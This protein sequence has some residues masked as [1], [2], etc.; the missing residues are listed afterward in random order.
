MTELSCPER[1]H[2]GA[3]ASGLLHGDEAT[4]L[5][6]HAELCPPC[7][8]ELADLESVVKTLRRTDL[9]MIDQDSPWPDSD[10][11]TV[12]GIRGLDS[13]ILNRIDT[14]KRLVKSRRRLVTV[15]AS[16][17][18][19]VAIAGG[20]AVSSRN[21]NQHGLYLAMDYPLGGKAKVELTPRTW[22]TEIAIEAKGLPPGITYGV[23]LERPDGT[24]VPAGS[25]TSIRSTMSLRFSSAL[26]AEQ[27]ESIG[28][29]DF[30]T[31]KEVR[32]LLSEAKQ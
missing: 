15:A 13:A 22:G 7:G 8:Q 24:R 10:W 19:L 17:V 31:K 4:A 12:P 6:K 21:R 29:T 26:S 32:V 5:R 2:L 11:S 1:T 18:L 30:K 9:S 23:W 20:I 3:L 25:F 27:A 16:L 28:M 14:E